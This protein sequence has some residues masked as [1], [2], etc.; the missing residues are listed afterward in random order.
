MRDVGLLDSSCSQLD[1]DRTLFTTERGIDAAWR[2]VDP[3]V[4]NG[5]PLVL[6]EP[7]TN[8]PQ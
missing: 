4:N 8:G 6:Y 7:G 5:I 2:I 1:G 3:I